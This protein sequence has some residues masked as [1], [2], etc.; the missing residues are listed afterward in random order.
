M[1][2]IGFRKEFRDYAVYPNFKSYMPVLV[3]TITMTFVRIC[4]AGG[5]CHRYNS[6]PSAL[7]VLPTYQCTK[8]CYFLQL[9]NAIPKQF[10]DICMSLPGLPQ[11]YLPR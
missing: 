11:Y 6:C 3:G 10:G 5:T 1:L 7:F 9:E 2:Q 4:Y 8:V